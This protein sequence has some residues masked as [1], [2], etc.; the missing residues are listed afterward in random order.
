[1]TLDDDTSDL[2]YREKFVFLVNRRHHCRLC[3]TLVCGGSS[4]SILIPLEITNNAITATTS[5]TRICSNCNRILAQTNGLA[6]F[7][8]VQSSEVELERE[9]CMQ[10]LE[11]LYKV[12]TTLPWVAVTKI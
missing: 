10:E 12:R 4:C 3:G 6:R 8:H 9:K 5:N 1:M 7:T 11:T 2:N